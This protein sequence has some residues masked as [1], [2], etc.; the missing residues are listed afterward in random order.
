MAKKPSRLDSGKRAREKQASRV[1]DARDL[2][3]GRRTAA[4]INRSNSMFGGF[5]E[6]ALRRARVIFPE[7]E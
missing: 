3:S 5:E 2:A 7:K 6:G 4:E 1:A